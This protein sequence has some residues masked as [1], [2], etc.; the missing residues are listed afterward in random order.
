L[1]VKVDAGAI[2]DLKIETIVPLASLPYGTPGSLYVLLKKAPGAF[3][4]GPVQNSLKFTVKEID[5]SG[6][7][8]DTGVDDEYQVNEFS[9]G[10]F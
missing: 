8:E 1:S 4:T 6:E 10:I 3:P 5:Q 2:K 9:I 7:P